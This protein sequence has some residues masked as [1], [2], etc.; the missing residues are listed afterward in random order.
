MAS[1]EKRDY[2]EVLGV[3]RDASVDE[4]KKAY[5]RLALKHHPD[6]NPGDKVAEERFKEAA[7][8]YAV[9]SDSDKRASYDRFGH[10]GMGGGVGFDPGQFTDFADILGDL[11]GF[12]DAFGG[13]RRRSN[14]PMRGA[15]VRFDLEL[16]FEEAVFGKEAVID[17]ARAATCATCAGSG[18]KKGTEPAV[19]SLCSGRGQV[20]YSQ[21]FF[22]MARTCPQCGGAGRVIQD[23]CAACTGAGRVR[24]QK[25]MT[26]KIPPGVDDGTRLR[27]AG[28]GEAG[29][30]GGP[31]GDLYVFIA[32]EEHP[33]YQRRDYD[34]H[35]EQT[36]SFPQA[37]LGA[38]IRVETVHGP[39]PLKVPAGTQPGQTFR[40]KG[41]G[42]PWIDGSGR[43]DHWAHIG[44]RVP[45]SLEP[46]EREILEEMAKLQGTEVSDGNVLRKVKEFFTGTD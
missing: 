15:D 14:R 40:I 11:F 43:G 8:A 44:I 20:R 22:A 19:C 10:A 35:S 16:A 29:T 32:V 27:L 45:T 39:E 42:V 6:K 24:E 31:A 9:L 36:I 30:N 7:E 17:L 26:V 25:Q 4:I 28:E 2:Y 13:A 37:A 46:R 18:A 12:G 21:G 38:E 34:I 23:P 33:R 1:T 3:A 5:R 41:K